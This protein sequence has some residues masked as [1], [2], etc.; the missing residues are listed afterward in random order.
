MADNTTLPAFLA[1]TAAQFERFAE[2]ATHDQ[3]AAAFRACAKILRTYPGAEA[4]ERKFDEIAAATSH[5]IEHTAQ[6]PGDCS[7][8]RDLRAL[9]AQ[10]ISGTTQAMLIQEDRAFKRDLAEGDVAGWAAIG[11]QGAE[12]QAD[13]EPDEY[14]ETTRCGW[15]VQPSGLHGGQLVRISDD[16]GVSFYLDAAMYEGLDDGA[17]EAVCAAKRKAALLGLPTD[18]PVPAFDV[19]PD[20]DGAVEDAMAAFRKLKTAQAQRAGGGGAVE[21]SFEAD[22]EP[23]DAKP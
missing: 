13:A 4:V 15:T 9:L 21:F 20:Q 19:E 6:Q 12:A 11:A 2:S 10:A 14:A 1:T 8:A 17:F 5:L 3:A 22:D 16:D 23:E 7:L 18:R